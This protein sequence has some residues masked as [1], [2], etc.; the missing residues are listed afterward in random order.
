MFTPVRTAARRS[1]IQCRWVHSCSPRV[2]LGSSRDIRLTQ[3]S[4]GGGWVHP[5][6]LGSLMFALGVVGFIQG[7]WVHSGSPLGSSGVVG[8]I[9]VRPAGRLV[10]SG[11]RWVHPR[12]LGS[13][14]FA[15]GFVWFI[16][17]RWVHSGSPCGPLDS[18]GVVGFTRFRFRDS[19][20][21][22]VS[23]GSLGYVME[24]AGFL[25]G[26]C[27]HSSSPWRSMGSSRVVKFT[28][29]RPWGRYSHPRALVSLRFTLGVTGFIRCR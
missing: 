27:V 18:S 15:L 7:C 19:W 24:D 21:H 11:V 22:A 2:L 10:C 14:R 17:G 1:V 23:L 26:R 12:W 9:R 6:S 28:W 5:G 25:R 20:V 29:V 13:L 8:F 4:L 16:G 3:V